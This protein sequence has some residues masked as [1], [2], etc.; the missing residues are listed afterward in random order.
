MVK[1][2]KIAEKVREMVRKRTVG[3]SEI[4]RKIAVGEEDG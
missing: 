3:V 1:D 4:A 2:R